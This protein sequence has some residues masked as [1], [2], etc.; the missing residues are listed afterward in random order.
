MPTLR[1]SPSMTDLLDMCSYKH[2]RPMCLCGLTYRLLCARLEPGR[3]SRL[4]SGG[5]TLCVSKDGPV[6]RFSQARSVC[7]DHNPGASWKHQDHIVHG[8][9]QRTGSP[10]GHDCYTL[11]DRLELRGHRRC[12]G[13]TVLRDVLGARW[14]R[15]HL[16]QISFSSMLFWKAGLSSTLQ[17]SPPVAKRAAR[18]SACLPHAAHQTGPQL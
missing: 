3:G 12:Q 6:P 13:H 15:S 4:A 7:L 8:T 11:A 10:T 2:A 5:D 9:R 1:A 16:I 14:K 18:A 17:V